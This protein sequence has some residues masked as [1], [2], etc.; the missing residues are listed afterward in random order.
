MCR[1]IPTIDRA[2][3]LERVLRNLEEIVTQESLGN[4]VRVFISDNCSE[5]RTPDVIREFA[6]SFPFASALRA[7]HRLTFDENVL[8]CF[9]A[10]STRFLWVCND[11]SGFIGE[12]VVR[13]IQFL[14]DH[15]AP[16][17]FF[18]VPNEGS[19]AVAADIERSSR[20]GLALTNTLINCSVFDREEVLPFYRSL[21]PEYNGSWLVFLAANLQMLH[22]RDGHA[23][24]IPYE[25]TRYAQFADGSRQRHSWSSD[26]DSYVTVGRIG[27]RLIASL[28]EHLPVPAQEVRAVFRARGWGLAA[29]GVYKRLRLGNLGARYT[30]EV[31]DE[32]CAH[33]TYTAPEKLLIRVFVSGG[34]LSVRLCGFLVSLV[35]MV[36]SVS[37]RV[38]SATLRTQSSARNTHGQQLGR[39]SKSSSMRS[40]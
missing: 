8:R 36:V 19:L 35:S 25:C 21:M 37:R 17:S 5:D 7:D 32:I 28:V 2:T 12:N 6:T 38:R 14:K 10:T 31:A 40:K 29:V 34:G 39:G 11:H 4:D 33:R 20:F 3:S 27:A 13:A 22:A 18:Y 9:E 30:A 16:G 1:S 26:W 23:F 15:D 24:L